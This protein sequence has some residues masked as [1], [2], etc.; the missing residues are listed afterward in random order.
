M[1]AHLG[2]H[3][4]AEPAA[5]L[6]VLVPAVFAE[7][8]PKGEEGEKHEELEDYGVF[9]GFERLKERNPKERAAS[10]G[11]VKRQ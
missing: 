6:L 3:E 1:L 4:F 11:R 9:H 2:F 8:D 10:K 5:V 7:G